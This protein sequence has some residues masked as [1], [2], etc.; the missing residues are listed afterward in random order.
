LIEALARHEEDKDDRNLAQMIWFGLA[1]RMPG[2]IKRAFAIAESTRL[3][4]LADSTYWYAA[5]LEGQALNLVTRRLGQETG[6][7][8]RRR[9]AGIELAM[10]PRANVSMPGAWKEVAPG[11]YA[12]SDARI[13]R[14]AERIAAAFGDDSMF[15]RLRETL[16]DPTAE[17]SARQHAFA[18]LSR[19]LDRTS[20]PVFL[21]LVTDT[22]FRGSAINLLGRFDSPEVAR[23]LIGNYED[24]KA[25]E[26]AAALNALTAR[27]SFANLLLDAVAAGKFKRDQLTAFHI[28][29]LA[30]LKN[31]DVDKRIA[32]TWGK[33]NQ[34]PAEKL[35]LMDRLE[36]AFSEAPLWAYSAQEGRKHFQK[37]CASCHRLRDEGT[38]LGPDLTGAGKNGIRYFLE[39][40]IDPNAVI[41]TDFQMTTVETRQD[42]VFSGLLIAETASAVTIRTTTGETVIPKSD[43]T[44]RAT[45]ENSLMPEGLLQPLSDRE[46]LELLK[47][48]ISN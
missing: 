29:Q 31:A 41:G 18:V 40:I 37:L 47:F 12:N 19:A 32:A 38:L 10:G 8:L 24:F 25:P 16:A 1:P 14:S 4:Q 28:R 45:S 35:S 33:V 11:L 20:L 43:I 9:L 5:T 44:A 3:P 27:V 7:N 39:N 23:A 15:P 17:A 26:R 36:K 22:A 6:V 2:D 13:V 21:K 34:S 30:Q 48:L 42:D 46:Q